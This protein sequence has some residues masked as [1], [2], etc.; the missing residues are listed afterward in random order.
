MKI[1]LMHFSE[2]NIQLHSQDFENFDLKYS[3]IKLYGKMIIFLKYF[4]SRKKICIFARDIER[5]LTKL[6]FLAN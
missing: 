2:R 1:D 6:R 4:T 5:T 3:E